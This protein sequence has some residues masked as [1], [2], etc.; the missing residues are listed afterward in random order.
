MA[1]T[2]N[3]KVVT[4]NLEICLDPK[5]P[6]SFA[7]TSSTT[8]KSTGRRLSNGV[9]ASYSLQNGA[10]ATGNS[11]RSRYI[12]SD[13]TNDKINLGTG[14]DVFN[15]DNKAF[16]IECWCY[17]Q[18]TGNSIWTLGT[19]RGA[20]QTRS[21][22]LYDNDTNFYLYMTNTI[23]WGTWPQAASVATLTMSY[24][25]VNG[26]YTSRWHHIVVTCESTTAT[27][28]VKVYAQGELHDQGTMSS[29][30]H[31][32]GNDGRS[33]ELF[34]SSSSSYGFQGRSGLFRYYS[35]VLTADE[36]MGNYNSS[37]S[38]YGF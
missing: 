31:N 8:I 22:D 11:F 35:S 5:D 12:S 29:Y 38:L 21:I 15:S 4:D 3:P 37:K 17:P 20:V 7:S 1:T 33:F 10:Y 30:S 23:S 6:N 26:G 32:Y 19:A 27:N 25:Q 36:V 16:S 28:G 9:P 18:A 13:G 24:P 34:G 2:H 14:E